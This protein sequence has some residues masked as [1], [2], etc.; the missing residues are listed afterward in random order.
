MLYIYFQIY[1]HMCITLFQIRYRGVIETI[2]NNIKIRSG[3][4]SSKFE[5]SNRTLRVR[6]LKSNVN[7][8]K[9]NRT[10][11][12]QSSNSSKNSNIFR[13]WVQVLHSQAF[14]QKSIDWFTG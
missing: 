7:Y 4:D 11:L 8:K 14:C 13:T 10:K 5:K 1:T 9:S 12:D 6:I 3:P 2:Y